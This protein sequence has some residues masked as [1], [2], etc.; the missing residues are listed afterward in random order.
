MRF[1][2]LSLQDAPIFEIQY[3]PFDYR[4][5]FFHK[6][7]VTSRSLPTMKHLLGHDNIGLIASS[8]WTTP[9]RFSVSVSKCVVEMKTGTHDRGTTFF[10]LYRYENIFAG[11]AE[12]V[13]NLSAD[14]VSD[15]KEATGVDFDKSEKATGRI[16][17]GQK[18]F[19]HGCFFC[20]IRQFIAI[21]SR[22]PFRAVFQ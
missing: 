11:K 13:C 1:S 12:R 6:D 20:F 21:N 2:N 7:A 15:W 17:L 9:D 4:K 5:I 3:R 10:P 19:Y 14:F 8:T 18:T 22:Q 16:P